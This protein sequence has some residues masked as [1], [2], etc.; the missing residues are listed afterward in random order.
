MERKSKSKKTHSKSK[1]KKSK[2]KKFSSSLGSNSDL[3]G[4]MNPSLGLNTL[5]LNPLGMGKMNSFF[6]SIFN[7]S[8]SMAKYT[9]YREQP[10]SYAMPGNNDPFLMSNKY[11][12]KN[13]F[14]NNENEIPI[15]MGDFGNL[16]PIE[17][18]IMMGGQNPFSNYAM[19]LMQPFIETH[20]K[21]Q[22]VDEPSVIMNET[23][24]NMKNISYF[25]GTQGI[26]PHP[27][28]NV[29]SRVN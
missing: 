7:Q 1:S 13:L 12:P 24:K 28:I 19:N 25:E 15:A 22:N 3:K 17:H 5:G 20:M 11:E 9:P 27:L 26:K 29:I 16:D 8:I 18:N 2:S 10:I 23:G 21:Y 14:G 6:P 4:M